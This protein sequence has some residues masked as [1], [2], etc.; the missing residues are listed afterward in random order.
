VPIIVVG[1]HSEARPEQRQVTYSEGKLLAEKF[2]CAFVETSSKYN[3][4]VS[5]AFELMIAQIE[6]LNV[7]SSEP[8]ASSSCTT[9]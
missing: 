8:V 6:K 9:M 1:N 4:N 3:E 2:Q 7:G 5:L